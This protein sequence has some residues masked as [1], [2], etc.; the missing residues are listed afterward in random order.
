MRLYLRSKKIDMMDTINRCYFDA[1]HGR[2]KLAL[3]RLKDL[4]EEL[5]EDAKIS[6]AEGLLRKDFLGQGVKAYDCFVKALSLDPSHA[7]AVCNSA[8]YAPDETEFRKWSEVAAQLSP[9]DAQ[10]FQDRSEI[11]DQGIYYGEFLLKIGDDKKPGDSAAYI[12]LGL[13]TAKLKQKEEV[14]VRRARAQ[15]LRLLDNEAEH[16]RNTMVEDF[17]P[18]ERLAL[19]EAI[20]EIELAIRLDEYDEELWNLKS[21]WCCLIGRYAESIVCAD[22]AIE[23]RPE[24]YCRPHQNKAMSLWRL[25]NSS[26]ALACIQEALRQAENGNQQEEIPH[27]KQMIEEMTVPPRQPTLADAQPTLAQAVRAAELTADQEIGLMK[28]NLQDI[29]AGFQMRID[30]IQPAA[31]DAM[32]YVPA[33]AQA[34]AYLSPETCFSMVHKIAKKDTTS[35]ENCM[36]A[37]LYIAAHTE[38]VMQ[39]DALR[40]LVLTIF[41]PALVPGHEE[42]VRTLYRQAILEVSAAATGRMAKLDQLMHQELAKIAPTMPRLIADQEPVDQAG[43]DRAERAILTK[44]QGTPFVNNSSEFNRV[45]IQST[46]LI[47][48]SFKWSGSDGDLLRSNLQGAFPTQ[49]DKAAYQ[50][51]KRNLIKMLIPILAPLTLLFIYELY[52]SGA[53]SDMF[54][55]VSRVAAE[56]RYVFWPIIGAVVMIISTIRSIGLANIKKQ[57]HPIQ[58]MIGAGVIGALGGLIMAWV[59][60][61]IFH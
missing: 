50:N 2:I 57:N 29:E 26:E 56:N 47:S 35:Y 31:N 8:E 10:S 53:I 42:G 54:R 28:G 61:L 41:V 6:Y 9:Q 30:V 7:F 39:H 44:L 13:L 5:G 23:L 55:E 16:H 20:A 45:R 11:F 46:P 14:K 27:L 36:R 25:D 40:L 38:A 59:L 51:G 43:K 24:G 19:A 4:E 49:K 33:M 52:I 32:P 17:P 15:K 12:E 37:T 21:A 34:L 3:E 48:D 58:G 18:D 22:R 60:K 1:D